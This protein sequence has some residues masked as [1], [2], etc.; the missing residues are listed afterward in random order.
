MTLIWF[1]SALFFE[2]LAA[3]GF[4]VFIIK[5]QQWVFR[6]SYWILVVGLICHTF[7]LGYRYY[8]L[9]TVPVLDL[10]S[11]LSVFAWSIIG[12]YLIIQA[13]FKLRVL[14]SFVAPFAA[15]LMIVSSVMPWKTSP[16]QESLA[17]GSRGDHIHRGWPVGHRLSGRHYVSDPGT[18]D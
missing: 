13:R 15:F 11:A 12:V 2:L 14:G 6:I 4:I 10:K 9:G 18:P 3:G 1:N 8:L 17:Y 5:Q 16:V 7:F